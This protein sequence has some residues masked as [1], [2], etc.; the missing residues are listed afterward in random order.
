MIP[1]KPKD[2]IWTDEQWEAIYLTGKNI[3]VSAGAGSGKTAVL[4]KRIIEKLK[5]GVSIN[6]MIIL[7]FTNAAAFEMK[8]RVRKNIEECIVNDSNL[9][10]QLYLIDQAV[11]TTFDS[12]SLSLVKKYHY[13]LGIDKN[14]G[15][16]DNA[17]LTVTKEQLLDEILEKYYSNQKFLNMLNIYTNKDDGL[18]KKAVIDIYNK[19]DSICKKE[20]Y[21]EEYIERYYSNNFIDSKTEE[22]MNIIIST[23]EIILTLLESI[24]SI[25]SNDKLLEK[26]TLIEETLDNLNYAKNYEDYKKTIEL[27]N[28]PIIKK[29]KNI[30][31]DD[32]TEIKGYY[33]K[34]KNYINDLKDLTNYESINDIKE[35][36]LLT[37]DTSNVLIDIIKDLDRELSI[38]KRSINSY[39]FSDITRLAIKLLEDNKDIREEIKYNTN[40]IMID[41][42]QDTNDIGDYFISLISNNNVYM[43]GDVKQ[44]IYRFRNANP[45]LFMEKYNSYKTTD[46][47]Y[48]LDLNKNFRFR[49]EVLNNINLIFNHIM[50][51]E[52]GGANYNNGHNMIYGNIDYEKFGETKQ[53]YNLE[54]YDYDYKNSDNKKNYTKDE[55]EIFMIAKDIK[56]RI[57]S[58]EKVFDIKSKTLKD[59]DYKDFV[60][61]VDRK[62]SFE[63]Y[64]KIFDYEGIPLILHKDEEFVYSN[65]IY[66]LKNILKLINIIKTKDYSNINYPFISVARS[67]L[68]EYNDNDI[69]T[70]VTNRNILNNIIFKDLFDKINNL[71]IKSKEKSLSGLLISIYEEFDMYTKTIKIGNI[72]NTNKKLDYLVSLASSLENIGYDLN[73]FIKY[74]DN[75]FDKKIDIEFSNKKD[76]T[77]NS[78]NIMTIHKSKGLE[79]PICYFPQL[80]KKFN[81]ADLKDKFLFEIQYGI[82]MPIFKEGLKNTIYKRLL[83]D[84]YLKEDIA[85]RLRVLYVALTRAK[86]KI[87]ML[88]G[89]NES[90][91]ILL[92]FN[93]GIVNN[94]ERLKYSSFE[95]VILGIKNILNPYIVKKQYEVNKAYQKIKK[96]NLDD[97]PRIEADFYNK[98]LTI[99]KEEKVI[100]SF[101]HTR[102]KIA[103]IDNQVGLNIHE[104]LE[105]LDFKN[106][107]TDINNYDINSYNKNKILKLFEMPFMEFINDSKVYKEYVFYSNDVTG[108]IDLLIESDDKYII[109]DYKLR[110]ID[111]DYYYN[112][113]KQYMNYIKSITNKKVE[114]YLYSIIDEKYKK[115][116]I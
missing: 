73:K 41:E 12:F 32:I 51:E 108:I 48:A 110:D 7:T 92:P 47:G 22:Y 14:V 27:F 69:F 99:T 17:I 66:V 34:L 26:I 18:I 29:T 52:I 24:K 21:L 3:I 100:N 25:V 107:Q 1:T 105:Y 6:D 80:Y 16:I 49:K 59:I 116:E 109:V 61:L 23:S 39:E 2:A 96:A 104:I 35:E 45:K 38:Y 81:K 10:E 65:E 37:K 4:T 9:K 64:K 54:I 86:E 95:D 56:D 89:I 36:I 20:Q 11:I 58:K 67:Y 72:D 115:I 74:F 44:S 93:N 55:I 103:K 46:L 30:D 78:V 42:Y 76:T 87:I 112:Q 57:K 60:I 50:D 101:S 33:D 68:F 40:E 94:L 62:T 113:V 102:N 114:G 97:I 90:D 5:L 31:E 19:M 13:L 77:S 91:N 111:K 85:E 98:E 15:I 28:L 88:D 63:L 82:V 53:N 70:S 8:E 43:V 84:N 83:S 75:I 106:H 79:Y 71:V